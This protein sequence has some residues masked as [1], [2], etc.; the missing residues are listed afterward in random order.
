MD[1]IEKK[2]KLV[3]K[4]FVSHSLHE[5]YCLLEHSAKCDCIKQIEIRSAELLLHSNTRLV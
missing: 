1:E 2:L 3:I 4:I 5:I